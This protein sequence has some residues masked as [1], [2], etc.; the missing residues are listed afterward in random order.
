METKQKRLYSRNDDD[1]LCIDEEFFPKL[2]AHDCLGQG[3]GAKDP[4]LRAQTGAARV[5]HVAIILPG[6]V[7]METTK[8]K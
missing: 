3:D 4:G 7:R 6:V 1:D 8:A 5:R 2:D